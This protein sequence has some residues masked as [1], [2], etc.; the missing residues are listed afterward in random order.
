MVFERVELLFRFVREYKTKKMTRRSL[1]DN[2][3]SA[4]QLKHE[5]ILRSALRIDAIRILAR[6]VR[7]TEMT[8]RP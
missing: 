1:R 7:S 8:S 5:V 2:G 6:F 3:Y 4:Q